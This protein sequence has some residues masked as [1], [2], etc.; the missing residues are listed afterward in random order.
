MSILTIDIT[1]S[2]YSLSLLKNDNISTYI[3]KS[4]LASSETIL[5]EINN[6]VLKNNIKPSD[7]NS[8]VYNNGPGSFTGIRVSSAIVQA[9]GFSNN[10]P[11]YG[12]NSLMLD[13]YSLYI[14]KKINKIQVIRKAFGD[15]LFHG[16]F[17][18]SEKEC[19]L[20]SKILTSNFNA[21]EINPEYTSLTDLKDVIK[22]KHLTIQD[23]TGSELLIDYYKKYSKKKKTFDYKD[24]LPSYAGHT[25]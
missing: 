16:L 12:I 22:A 2:S 25:I 20:D 3:D 21:I 9:I 5:S 14:E 11:V 7:I 4:D 18:L 10:C 8:V 24:A 6:L 13:A 17:S 15:Q 23:Y 19:L 1:K